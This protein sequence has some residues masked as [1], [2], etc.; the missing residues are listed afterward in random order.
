MGW[1]R[2]PLGFSTFQV[3]SYDYPQQTLTQQKERKKSLL[4][5]E[6]TRL[7]LIHEETQP[8]AVQQLGL[9]KHCLIAGAYLSP[10]RR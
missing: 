5:R 3:K 9:G 6:K 10:E 1:P 2:N 4:Q 8:R 7:G